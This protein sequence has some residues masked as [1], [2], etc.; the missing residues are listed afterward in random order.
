MLNL[1]KKKS[2]KNEVQNYMGQLLKLLS[3]SFGGDLGTN[4]KRAINHIFGRSSW[5]R[6]CVAKRARDISSIPFI[7]YDTSNGECKII[8]D[9]P[10]L[11]LLN[12]FN[13][14]M[15]G[16]Q[17]RDL[18][19]RWYDNVGE[20]GLW[21]ET[22]IRGQVTSLY[23]INPSKII[24]MG[25]ENIDWIIS[26]EAGEKEIPDSDFIYLKD[27]NP[28]D[29]YGRGIG[30]GQSA[31]DE[32][33]IISKINKMLGVTF[34]NKAV[35]PYIIRFE[36]VSE[37]DI[38]KAREDWF[39]NFKGFLKA[40]IPMFTNKKVDIQKMAY[41]FE[42]TQIFELSKESKKDMRLM[43]G[44]PA[45]IIG[46]EE[47]S[48]KATSVNSWNIY[49]DGV[50][51]PAMELLVQLLNIKL[52]PRFGKNLKLGYKNPSKTD[53]QFK[54]DVMK[55]APYSFTRNEY[56]VLARFEEW[57]GEEGKKIFLPLNFAEFKGTTKTGEEKEDA[58]PEKINLKTDKHLKKKLKK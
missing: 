28:N 22:G 5:Y 35:P 30:Q 44:I 45:S 55:A 23:P 51:I 36:G 40:G 33:S 26:T 15:L 6:M 20:W 37:P 49:C 56:R 39:N 29:E 31:S 38:K 53:T 21:L 48:N 50:T 14:R 11:D 46:E 1:F 17:A 25:S 12:Q 24:R 57:E 7:L 4:N 8:K 41:N 52:T 54:L 16:I 13:P 3:D 10:Y 32:L 43:W 18:L 9:H 19:Q 34:D 2:N 47:N 27:I 42:E 58:V